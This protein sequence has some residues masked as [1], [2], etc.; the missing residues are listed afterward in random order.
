MR[1]WAR[2]SCESASRVVCRSGV[3]KPAM[4][5]TPVVARRRTPTA[6][7]S[8]AGLRRMSAFSA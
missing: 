3:V 4:S 5:L 2:S 8:H 7:P 1:S 6:R